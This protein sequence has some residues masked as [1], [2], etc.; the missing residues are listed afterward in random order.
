MNSVTFASMLTPGTDLQTVVLVR[1]IRAFGGEF[2]HNPIWIFCP[3]PISRAAQEELLW[4]DVRL[5][6]IQIAPAARSFPLAT[7][8]FTAATA[9]QMALDETD[10]LIWMDSDTLVINPPH[11]LLLPDHT[12]LGC[13]PVH[14]KLI[15]SPYDAPPDPFWTLIYQQCRAVADHIFPVMTVIDR[16]RIRATFNAGLL[17][18]RPERRLLQFWREN[19][20]RLYN[21]PAFQEFYRQNSL[22]Q[23]FM[24]QAVLSGTIFAHLDREEIHQFSPLVNYPL[25]LHADHPNPPD[26]I[27]GLVTCRYDIF[28]QTLRWQERL[29]ATGDLLDWITEQFRETVH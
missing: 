2:S 18:V 22:Y 8:V 13:C 1:S 26:D 29:P 11:E 25:H 16:Q 17:V 12:V 6:P 10:L 27:N 5:I 20:L 14:L 19:F 28:F 21:D 24:H 4:L 9:E 7:K 23:I 15:N 3:G